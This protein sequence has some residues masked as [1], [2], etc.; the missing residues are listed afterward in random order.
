M[1]KISENCSDAFTV[2]NLKKVKLCLSL[3]FRNSDFMKKKYL[4]THCCDPRH[5]GV[6]N[7]LQ[8][9]DSIWHPHFFRHSLHVPSQHIPGVPVDA[10]CHH[11][12]LGKGHPPVGRVCLAGGGLLRNRRLLHIPGTF[13]RYV[14]WA[15]LQSYHLLT[16]S[17]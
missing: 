10:E 13:A 16:P 17:T 4:Q 15:H 14:W 3:I 8:S 12:T 7:P 6:H 9:F 1:N 2:I 5:T 11:G